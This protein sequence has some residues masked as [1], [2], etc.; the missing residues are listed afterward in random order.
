MS[1]AYCEINMS[2]HLGLLSYI[3]IKIGLTML[4]WG[5]PT[6]GVKLLE[7]ALLYFTLIFL[8]FKKLLV[9][10]VIHHGALI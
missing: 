7:T 4:P 3:L 5:T 1:S 9:Y 6:S 8:L 2:L 10:F